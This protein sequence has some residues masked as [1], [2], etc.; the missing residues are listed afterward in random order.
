MKEK[1]TEDKNGY[2]VVEEYSEYEDYTPEELAEQA[3]KK[4]KAK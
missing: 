4:E 2:T 3:E 1:V